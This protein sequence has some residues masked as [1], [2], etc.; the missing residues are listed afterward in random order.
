MTK[1]YGSVINR[2]YYL[3]REA[4][5]DPSAFPS[6]LYRYPPLILLL[7][8]FDPL[9]FGPWIS[10][11]LFLLAPLDFFSYPSL[12]FVRCVRVRF[13]LARSL[14][15]NSLGYLVKKSALVDWAG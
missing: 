11:P 8:L 13:G 12:H 2:D 6:P 5:R 10:S 14:P 4:V 1:P 9:G 15:D 3:V 7:L